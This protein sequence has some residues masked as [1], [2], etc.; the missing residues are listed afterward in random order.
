MS[1]MTF[2]SRLPKL[3][4]HSTRIC[5]LYGTTWNIPF[6]LL[7]PYFTFDKSASTSSIFPS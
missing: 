1:L 3:S 2:H 4:A 7:P 5:F 6:R